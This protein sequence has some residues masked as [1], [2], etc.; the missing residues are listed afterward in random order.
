[1]VTKRSAK[2]SDMSKTVNRLESVTDRNLVVIVKFVLVALIIAVLNRLLLL[3]VK[4]ESVSTFVLANI[5]TWV[6][7]LAAIFATTVGLI[8]GFSIILTRRTRSTT[9]LKKQVVKAFQQAL[10][11]SSFNPHPLNKH[12]QRNT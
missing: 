5:K 9:A 7:A 3:D 6:I 11:E 2:A 12:E 1:M 4:T 8:Y 10:D